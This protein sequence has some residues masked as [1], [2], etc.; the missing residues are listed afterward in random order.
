MCRRVRRDDGAT[1]C[2]RR[3]LRTLRR[4]RPFLPGRHIVVAAAATTTARVATT[5]ARVVCRL[6]HTLSRVMSRGCV[7]ARL[8]VTA[9][10]APHPVY[11]ALTAT[12]RTCPCHQEMFAQQRG[13]YRALESMRLATEK[14]RHIVVRALPHRASRVH[15]YLVHAPPR[16]CCAVTHAAKGATILRAHDLCALVCVV[17]DAPSAPA[18]G[19]VRQQ[20]V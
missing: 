8:C 6:A 16:L 14:D 2:A 20:C 17:D 1:R 3:A 10:V 12:A 19:V 4:G 18:D 5:T 13:S 9:W 11:C 15:M 7:A